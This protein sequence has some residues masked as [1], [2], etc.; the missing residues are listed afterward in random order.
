M[1]SDF[2]ASGRFTHRHWYTTTEADARNPIM[3]ASSLCVRP[4]T[5]DYVQPQVCVSRWVEREGAPGQAV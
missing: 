3:M 5:L 4:L 1:E 2:Q